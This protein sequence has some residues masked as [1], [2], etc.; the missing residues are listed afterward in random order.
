VLNLKTILTYKQAIEAEVDKSMLESEGIAANLLNRDSTLDGL[1]GPF[2][3]QLQVD[4]Q[5]VERAVGLIRSRSPGRFGNE[6]NIQ[7]AENAIARGARRYLWFGLSSIAFLFLLETVWNPNHVEFGW[8]TGANI[9]LGIFFSIPIWL[10]YE[11]LRKLTK[12]ANQSSDRT[13]RSDTPPAG[14][15]SHHF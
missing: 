2:L 14:H 13:P 10:L 12:G 9:V 11:W 6:T 5:N 4:D 8:L 15:E 7:N 1:G 3:I